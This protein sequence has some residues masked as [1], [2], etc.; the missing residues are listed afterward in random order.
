MFLTCSTRFFKFSFAEYPVN[1]ILKQIFFALN[2]ANSLFCFISW[3]NPLMWSARR[4]L[5][6]IRINGL[7]NSERS[8]SESR[9]P[10]KWSIGV[11][12]VLNG[13]LLL[14]IEANLLNHGLSKSTTLI[15]SYLDSPFIKKFNFKK[16]TVYPL[17]CFILY[18]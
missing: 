12:F 9:Y 13:C 1:I 18:V 17:S 16:I 14:T 7:S 10:Q 2:K 11:I 3:N 6:K 5:R 8:V 15:L 4:L